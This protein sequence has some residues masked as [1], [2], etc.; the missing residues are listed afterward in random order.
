MKNSKLF[1]ACHSLFRARLSRDISC[2]V[3]LAILA[4]EI[5]ILIPSYRREEQDLLRQLEDVAKA[6][7]NSII[8]LT[9]SK[10]DSSLLEQEIND[11]VNESTAI[12]GVTIYDRNGKNKQEFGKTP[13]LRYADL[14]PNKM[15]IQRRS[16][17]RYYDVA[18]SSEYLGIDRVLIIRHN[19]SDLQIELYKYVFRIS[20]LVIIIGIFV[21]G[22]TM[23]AVIYIVI[24]PILR[25]RDDLLLAGDALSHDRVNLELESFQSDRKDE[26]GE[27]MQAFQDMFLRVGSE[28]AERKKASE[29]LAQEQKK[30]EQ[31]LLNILPRSIAE[32]LKEGESNI[33]K[34]YENVTILFADIVGFTKLSSKISPEELVNLL[35][36]IF[37]IFD[38]LT[39]RYNL[40]KI[41]TIGD[42][43]MAVGGLPIPQDDNTA[44]VANMAL[45]M[46]EELKA[47]SRK[48]EHDLKIRIG[49]NTGS[50]I[51]GVIGTK[52]FIYDLWGDAVNVASRM[53][54]HGI[55]GKIQVTEST[56]NFLKDRYQFQERGTIEIKGKGKMLVYLLNGKKEK[57]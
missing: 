32:S 43:Y 46:I 20:I 47:I 4:I 17:R 33:A 41:K 35:N 27:V 23:I 55:P 56:Y 49:M 22:A 29:L 36:E 6:K 42:N 3:F 53:E 14:Q 57:S 38:R 44:S 45:D 52:K 51:A 25:L 39:D 48:Y 12:A 8:I 37:S 40:E 10:M 30:S 18:L 50:V 1:F 15:K 54:S 7:I 31:L 13:T 9:Q 19:A 16:D 11:L 2:W 34:K 21:T 28:I 26:L 5:L 24:V